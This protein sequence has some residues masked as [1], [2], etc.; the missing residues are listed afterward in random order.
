MPRYAKY[1]DKAIYIILYMI[2]SKKISWCV[3][4]RKYTL[5]IFGQIIS[6]ANLSLVLNG[7]SPP[8]T[9]R[10]LFEIL[11]NQAEIRLYLPFSG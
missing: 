7:L 1:P 6:G 3:Q 2:F 4:I 11:L 10:N 8:Y 9:Q 5:G